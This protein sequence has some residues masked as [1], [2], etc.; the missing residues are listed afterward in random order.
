MLAVTNGLKDAGMPCCREIVRKTGPKVLC[1]RF[2][3]RDQP[4]SLTQ[5]RVANLRNSCNWILFRTRL[6]LN[7]LRIDKLVAIGPK[8]AVWPATNKANG[9]K[10]ILH[11][12]E[13]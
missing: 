10:A 13:N 12:A 5:V 8:N 1:V 2:C 7:A 6:K 3:Y 9:G 4:S 11:V